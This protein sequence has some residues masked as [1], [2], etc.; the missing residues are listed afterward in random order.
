MVKKKTVFKLSILFCLAFWPINL[1][2][3]NI[4][5]DFIGYIIPSMLLTV[6]FLLWNRE[7]QQQWVYKLPILIIPFFSPKLALFPL[8]FIIL[9]I[10]ISK[11]RKT[12]VIFFVV[13]LTVLFIQWQP[14]FGQTI[15]KQDYEAQQKVIRNTYLYPS[16][17]LARVFENK[18]RIFVDKFSNNFF[19][20]TDPSNY[21][22]GFQPRQIV[23]DN[24]NLDK[25]PFLA[26]I[27]F[28]VGLF[29]LKDNRNLT[30]ICLSLIAGIFCL[31][32]LSIFDR[33][34]FIL[35]LPLSLIIAKGVEITY[36][37]YK[38]FSLFFIVF[39]IPQII[40]ILILK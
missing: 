14:F 5:S 31:S 1:L 20:L 3:A 28:V 11:A 16:V 12:K 27:F 4:F 22:F 13:A 38:L 24:Q 19:A 29:Y 37:R 32:T 15:F 30:F 17:L 21:F 2:L 25:F 9:D 39:T 33:N 6:S 40:R 34:D 10:L 8:I 35:W 7:G 26:I 36:T 18:P 23:N